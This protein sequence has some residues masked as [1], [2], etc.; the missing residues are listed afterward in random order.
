MELKDFCRENLLDEKIFIVPS[1]TIGMQMVNKMA[2][3]GYSSINLKVV[4]LK[5]LA[6]EILEEDIINKKKIIIDSILGNSLIINILKVLVEE[7]PNGFFKPNLIDAKTAEELYKVIMELKYSGLEDYPKIKDLD[8]IY[9]RYE[10]KLKELN[11]LD[12]CD[13]IIEA[14]KSVNINSYRE[15]KIAIAS[16]IEFNNMEE[17]LFKKL[18]ENSCVKIQ[19]PVKTVEGRPEN[20]YYKDIFNNIELEGKKI[21]FYEAYGTKEEIG[22]IIKDM[23]DKRIPIDEVVIAVT[24]NKYLDLI[25]IEFEKENI[26]ITFG[27]GLDIKSSSVY[28]FINTIFTWAKNYYNVNEIKTIFVNGDIKIDNFSAPEIYEELVK[29]KIIS[30]RE[31]YN[32]ILSNIK[33]RRDLSEGEIEKRIWLKEFFAEL[34]ETIPKSN[35]LRFNQYIPKFINL[36]TKYVKSNNKY[37]GAAKQVVLETLYKIG[38]IDMEVSRDEYFDIVLSYIEQ[39]KILRAQPHPGHIFAA[40]FGNAGYTGRKYLYLIGLDSDSLSNKV[41]ESPILLDNIFFANERYEYKKYKIKEL[42]TADFENISIGYSNFDTVNIKI[43]S[44]SQIYNELKDIAGEKEIDEYE[45]RERI[46]YGRDM[47]KSAT[48]LETLAECP[49]KFYFKNIMGLIPKEDVDIRVDRWL[50]GLTKGLIAHKVLNAY[51]NLN[52]K[53]QTDEILLELVEEECINAKIDNVCL[54]EEVYLREKQSLIDICKSIIDTTKEDKEWRVLV[55]ELSFGDKLYKNNNFFG[56]LPRQKIN[57]VGLE[58]NISGAI[59]RVDISNKD[60]NV[61]RIVDYKTGNMDNFDKKLRF[62][63][64]RGKNKEYNYSQTQKLQYYVY[65]KA[66]EKILETRKDIIN[67][68]VE[69]FTYIFGETEKDGTIDLDFSDEF[70]NTIENRIK[71]LLDMDILEAQKNIIYDPEQSCRYCDYSSICIVDKDSSSIKEEVDY[72]G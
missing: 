11:A 37:D 70:I 55:N 3:K 36:I 28:R 64:G 32:K 52:E 51:F 65:K 25:N 45:N 53:E 20:Y 46:I 69:K 59:D 1:R 38:D 33:N 14:A 50:D 16:N 31:N 62:S 7:E 13:I 40:S 71:E 72:G 47:V 12:Y 18:T 8:K 61:F 27:E 35:Y 24:N 4:T 48:S 43:Q 56:I 67:P 2:R 58:L 63:T 39:S 34:F 66:L 41:V 15:N 42:L 26:P 6:F 49:R 29:C 60:E 22:T 54:L 5:R 19:M 10:N 23:K 9:I 57:V 68:V 21:K 44:P 30:L 17:I